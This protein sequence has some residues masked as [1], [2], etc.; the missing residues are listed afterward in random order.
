MSNT[1]PTLFLSVADVAAIV[2]E[3]GVMRCLHI[4]GIADYIR[5]DYLRWG[6]FDKSARVAS[7]WDFGV[8]ELMPIADGEHYTA[9]STST[10]T[11]ATPSAACPP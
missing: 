6:E 9:S 3:R 2:R 7:H 1:S 10:A 4:A 11:R 5:A 8:I